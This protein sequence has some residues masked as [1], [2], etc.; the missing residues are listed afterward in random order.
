MEHPMTTT[1]YKY[2]KF[3]SRVIEA[4]KENSGWFAKP[5]TFN[6][7]FDSAFTLANAQSEETIRHFDAKFEKKYGIR[8]PPA[9]RDPSVDRK[10]FEGFREDIRNLSQNE[11]GLFC[12]SE[13]PDSILMWSHYA[14]SHKGFCVAYGRRPSTMLDQ[15]AKQVHYSNDYPSFTYEDF[16]KYTATDME[17]LWLTKA[18]QWSYEREWRLI[19]PT[20][21]VSVRFDFPITG[22]IFGMRM[23]EDH[24]AEIRNALSA[25]SDVE[26][27]QA[28]AS[29]TEFCIKIAGATIAT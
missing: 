13:T 6:D 19:H 26:Y 11:I 25:S 28:E 18:Q 21:N 22:I 27:F 20:G 16:E 2:R 10:I 14:D 4:L 23:C 29:D 8:V 15:I 7:P 1:L 5:S 3:G 17:H 9:L 24:R 12:V